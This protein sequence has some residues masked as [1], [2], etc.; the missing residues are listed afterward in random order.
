[1]EWNWI[2]RWEYVVFSFASSAPSIYHIALPTLPQWME[3]LHQYFGNIS[4]P[5]YHGYDHW[6]NVRSTEMKLHLQNC[7]HGV[8][9][10]SVSQWEQGTDYTLQQSIFQT[11]K[12]PAKTKTSTLSGMWDSGAVIAYTSIFWE[13]WYSK[14]QVIQILRNE[15]RVEILPRPV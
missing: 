15:E 2:K 12:R 9:K 7:Q 8:Q 3:K 10:K 13:F 4:P 6:W 11:Q 1:M 14:M 5:A